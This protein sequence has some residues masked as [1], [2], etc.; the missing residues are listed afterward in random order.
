MNRNIILK[1]SEILKEIKSAIKGSDYDYTSGNIGKAVFLLSV[2]MVLEMIME[3]VFAVTD[4]YFVSR[5]GADAVATVGITESV[6]TII[7]AIAVGMSMATTAI[8]AR[9]IGEKKPKEA[10]NT[11]FH[12]IMAGSILSLFIAVPG[13]LFA[14]E[15]LRIMGLSDV[16]SREY[17]GYTAIMLGSNMVIML[18][19]I[20]NAVFRSAGDAAIS[21]RVLWLANL[22]NLLL[23]PLLIFGW[24]PIPAL[25]VDGA[26]IAT[27]TGRG[28]AVVYQVYL[29]FAGKG[30]IRLNT[31]SLKI[32]FTLMWNLIRV[33]LGGVGQYIIATSS[34]IGLMRIVSLFGAE[35]V[36]G[37]TIGIRIIIFVLLPSLGISNAAA[38]L[39]GQ[40][41]GAGQSDRAEKS[42]WYAGRVNLL[43]LGAVG[44]IMVAWPEFFIRF[45]MDTPQV[46][47]S[48]VMCLRIVSIGF[49]SY[50]LGMVLINSFNGAGDTITPTKINLFCFWLLEIPLAYFLAVTLGLQERGVFWAIVIAETVLTAIAVFIFRRGYWKTRTV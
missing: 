31:E 16:I 5:L 13:V 35:V 17:S 42:V 19:F 49:L 11:A 38:T 3:S 23:D 39:V 7:Y 2:P 30:R 14:E 28:L 41:L 45:F 10:A 20:I 8:V 46:I 29:L 34:W 26:A 43:I 36:A 25:G 4:I 44:A 15:L 21:M 1:I 24:G 48:G 6:V 27:A 9:R 22:L 40:N 50:A 18:L 12:A 37:Y 47:E 33:S 32:K